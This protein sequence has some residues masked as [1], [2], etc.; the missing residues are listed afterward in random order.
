MTAAW[1]PAIPAGDD[2]WSEGPL[3]PPISA[4][5]LLGD[6][7]ALARIGGRPDGGVDRVAG[8]EADLAARRWLME[9]MGQAG[10]V[11][12]MDEAGNVLGRLAGS[13]PPWLLVGSHTDTVPAGGRLDGAYGVIA[14]LEVMRALVE[15]GDQ[16]AGRI[17]LVSFADEEGVGSGGGLVGSTALCAGPH[18]FD[19]RGYLELH[20]EQGP[21][22]EAAGLELGVVEGIVGI[23]RWDVR[24]IGAANH[25][26]TTPMTLRRDAGAAAGAV[27]AG[28]AGLLAQVD[29]DMV[30]NIGRL[31][32][33]PG[34]TNVVPAEAR[35]TV[36]LRAL[37]PA[38]LG[39]AA[40]ALDAAVAAACEAAGCSYEMVI[41]SSHPPAPMDTTFVAAIEAVCAGLGR[42]HTRLISG[43]GHDAG[44]LARHLPTGMIFVP[45]RGGISHSP[46]EHTDPDH[47]ITGCAVLLGSALRVLEFAKG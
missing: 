4:D 35:F 18:R 28:L 27:M 23:D 10:L 24:V 9:R 2:T 16:A 44:T 8:S 5:R 19:L 46:Q 47:L 21:S 29:P 33:L 15:S 6:L 39:T 1:S 40:G 25:A 14:G 26:G 17:E 31:E 32:L 43:A 37:D 11:A 41:S 7:E 12:W 22:L 30:G 38:S 42:R 20:I 45:S 3:T 34:A 36:E 13:S